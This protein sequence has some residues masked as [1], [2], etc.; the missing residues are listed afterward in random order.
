[1]RTPGIE[2]QEEFA[3]YFESRAEAEASGG[4]IVAAA[5]EA[6]RLDCQSGL[7]ARL[8]DLY[9]KQAPDA[10]PAVPIAA[11]VAVKARPTAAPRVIQAQAMHP[12]AAPLPERNSP[13]RA[14]LV[15]VLVECSMYSDEL[16]RP[17]TRGVLDVILRPVLSGSEHAT[18]RRVV[19]TWHELRAFCQAQAMSP[20]SLT[21]LQVA[22]FVERS[23][24]RS[25]VLPSLVFMAKHL[26]FG[27]D[28][29]LAKSF[30]AAQAKGVGHG[31]RQAAVAQ[32][33]MLVRLEDGIMSSFTTA[34]PQW[35]A[36]FATPWAAFGSR[37][38]S[39]A[40]RHG[41]PHP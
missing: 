36:L 3:F 23:R 15:K 31:A 34:N 39:V 13:L 5:W 12:S 20:H 40:G 11:S 8:R 37:M 24:A 27:A 1:M 30:R 17:E 18:L 6:A 2:S 14:D 38:S 7:G 10:R 26:H 19:Q 29:G 4:P 25:R 22:A 21:A 41:R 16:A 35:L 33:A 32:P 28:L 9:A